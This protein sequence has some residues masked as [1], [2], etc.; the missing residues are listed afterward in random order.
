MDQN[1]TYTVFH[2]TSLLLQGPLST[3]LQDLKKQ[4][5]QL[6][7]HLPVLIFE[8]QTGR[9]VDFNLQ[10]PIP[11]PA[12]EPR[13]TGAGRPKLGVVAREVTLL[14]RHWEWLER[15]PSGASA[16]LRRLID[17]ARKAQPDRE[18]IQQAQAATDRFMHAIAGDLPGYQEASRAL[19]ACNAELFR[20]HIKNWPADIR[21]HA[22]KLSEGAFLQES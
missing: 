22:L 19:Y 15:Q 9:T 20:E 2:G 16:T 8:D 5:G 21:E 10:D 14:P 12:P 3:V 7:P 4:Q 17:E 11:G 13:R 1:P 18:R 6:D